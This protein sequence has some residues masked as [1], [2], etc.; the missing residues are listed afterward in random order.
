MI[1]PERINGSLEKM[2]SAYK[3]S[4]W[5]DNICKKILIPKKSVWNW[6][7]KLKKQ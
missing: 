3:E 6:K 1:P 7:N 2:A 4:L 5:S